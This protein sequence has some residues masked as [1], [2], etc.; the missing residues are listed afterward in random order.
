MATLA[1]NG[2]DNP[3]E[4]SRIHLSVSRDPAKNAPDLAF[5]D[6]K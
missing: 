1:Y 5:I 6:G 4:I 2:K 3:I